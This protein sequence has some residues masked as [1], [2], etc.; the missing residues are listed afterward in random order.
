MAGF[1]TG[2]A[3]SSAAL[4]SSTASA[5]SAESADDDDIN[6][7]KIMHDLKKLDSDDEQ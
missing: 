7:A 4:A 2:L 1:A 6:Y 3:T 5:P